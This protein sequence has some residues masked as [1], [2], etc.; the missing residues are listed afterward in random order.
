MS[1]KLSAKEQT[2]QSCAPPLEIHFSFGEYQKRLSAIREMMAY[3][4]IDLLYLSS[5][6]SLFYVS[7]Y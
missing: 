5:P 7:G 3:E 1:Y 6:E 4:K 2:L